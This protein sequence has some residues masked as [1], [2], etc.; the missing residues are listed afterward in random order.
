MENEETKVDVVEAEEA[1]KTAEP[2]Q[3]TEPAVVEAPAEVEEAVAPVV[4]EKEEDAVAVVQTEP[5]TVA[6][7]PSGDT[8]DRLAAARQFA[9]AKYDMIRRAAVEQFEHV[10]KYTNDAREQL[11]VRWDATCSK[12]KKLHSAGEEFVKEHPTGTAFGALGIGVIL[13]LL[14]GGSRR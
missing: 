7:A 10:R 12:A 3:A 6:P 11:N 9:V 14:L 8:K 2:V 13:G 5:D 4:E 1:V